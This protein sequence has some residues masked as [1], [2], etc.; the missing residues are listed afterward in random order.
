MEPKISVIIVVFNG[1]NTLLHAIESVMGESYNNIEL[2]VVDGGSTDGTLA[3]LRGY[4]ANNFI[5]KSEPDKGI[6]DAMNKGLKMA[7][8]EWVYFLGADDTFCNKN[9]LK[10]IFINQINLD[11]DFL[12]GNVYSLALKK[13]YDGEFNE[14][15]ILFQNICH[16]SI[17]YKRRIHE[18]VGFYNEKYKTFSDW[19]FNIRCFYNP[20]IKRKYLDIT[21]ANFAAGGI[22]SSNP[23]LEFLRNYLF[24]KNLWALNIKGVKKLYDI[25]FYDRWWRLLRS[26]KLPKKDSIFNYV[27]KENIPLEITKMY[28]FQ[29]HIP[30]KLLWIGFFS[31]TF[32]FF[33][34][35]SNIIRMTLK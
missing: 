1:A 6:Y 3:I 17:F 12:Y 16:Q 28:A 25:A 13:K 15:K 11:C 27:G 4:K 32:M 30:F 24:S 23:D 33:S 20:E 19:D 14:E 21:I 5:W 29:R 22:G 7:T 2:I 18:K 26:L 8:G 31:K 10:E 9:V 34:Y 35:F